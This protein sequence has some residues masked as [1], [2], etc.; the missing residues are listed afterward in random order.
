MALIKKLLFCLFISI[1][2]ISINFCLGAQN[3]YFASEID[4]LEKLSEIPEQKGRAFTDLA[5]L[6]QLSGNREKALE[7]WMAASAADPL[8]R[9]DSALLEAVKLLISMG[10][11]DRAGAELRTILLSNRDE[12][13]QKSAMVLF[14]Q[15]EAY[16]TGDCEPLIFLADNANL[17]K[18]QNS[19]FYTLW[20]ISYNESWKTRLLISFPNSA[21]TEIIR[22]TPGIR[23]AMTPQWLL[24]PL[25]TAD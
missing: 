1:N 15:L 9:D 24:L 18:Y 10:E 5:R 13:I 16:K 2:F 12:E 25:R 14:A 7:Y 17:K 20:K 6:Y 19:I 23:A 4:R 21:E 3:I 22:E 8:W 11:F